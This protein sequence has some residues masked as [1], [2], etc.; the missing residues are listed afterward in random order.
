M[1]RRPASTRPCCACRFEEVT[2]D[3]RLISV[4]T[5]VAERAEMGGPDAGRAVDFAIPAGQPSALTLQGAHVRLLGLRH[6]LGIG[7]SFPLHLGFERA[8]LVIATLNVDFVA[9][10]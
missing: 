7:R 5:P 2:A 3:D 4:V 6:G 8:G 9:S 10:R 1:R